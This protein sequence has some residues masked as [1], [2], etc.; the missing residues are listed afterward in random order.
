MFCNK[1]CRLSYYKKTKLSLRSIKCQECPRKKKNC[2][3]WK[4]FKGK[5]HPHDCPESNYFKK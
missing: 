4:N 1:K 5:T 3:L 2:D